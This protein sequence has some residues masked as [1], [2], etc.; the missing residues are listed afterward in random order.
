LKSFWKLIFESEK[1]IDFEAGTE[2]K[3]SLEIAAAVDNYIDDGDDIDDD[4]VT[5]DIV[6]TVTG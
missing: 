2:T 6:S 5:G 4:N 3:L 1:K